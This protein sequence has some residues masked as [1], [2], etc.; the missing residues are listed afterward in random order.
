LSVF[1]GNGIYI[2]VLEGQLQANGQPLQRR[3]GLGVTQTNEV[4][5]EA[6]VDSELLAVEV[7]MFA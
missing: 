5:V 1:P 2:L 3:D 7:P 4:V 6:T